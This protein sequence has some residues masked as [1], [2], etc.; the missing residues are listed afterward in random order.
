M[1]GNCHF[2][3]SATVCAMISVN[4]NIISPALPNIGTDT[5]SV[6]LLLMGGILGGLLPDMDNPKSSI[7]KISVPISTIICKIGKLFG[8][9][10][11][12]DDYGKG[13]IKIIFMSEDG[14]YI[15]CN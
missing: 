7:G 3:Y 8:R 15:D 6:V 9:G 12:Y 1:N 10:G 11:K 5:T 2:L 13:H 14:E 4:I